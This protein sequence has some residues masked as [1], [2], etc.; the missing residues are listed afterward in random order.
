MHLFTSLIAWFHHVVGEPWCYTFIM[1]GTF[2][3]I[4]V[5]GSAKYRYHNNEVLYWLVASSRLTDI[6]LLMADHAKGQYNSMGYDC[7]V[8]ARLATRILVSSRNPLK[9]KKM[10]YYMSHTVYVTRSSRK[11]DVEYML[12]DVMREEKFYFSLFFIIHVMTLV[13]AVF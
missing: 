7:Y 11:S 9:S 5:E 2:F 13:A 8:I 10:Y 3:I 4:C 1:N 12:Q 6:S